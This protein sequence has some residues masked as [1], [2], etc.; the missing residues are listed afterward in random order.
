MKVERGFSDEE[1]ISS[2]QNNREISKV[3]DFMY[4]NYFE[5]LKTIILSNNG[6]E[7]DAQDIMQEVFVAFI[8]LVRKEKY[9][10]EASVRSFL[11]TLT[12]NMWFSEAR[13]RSSA[14]K[15]DT[16]FEDQKDDL[17]KDVTDYL[18]YSEGLKFVSNLF[19]SLGEVCKKILTLF[20]FKDLPMR[21]ILEHVDYEN[22]QVLRN[23]KYKCQRELIKRIEASPALY[24]NLKSALEHGR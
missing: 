17:E 9:R 8:D 12:R 14:L 7:E 22:E 15:R 21:E 10:K 2:I 4:R 6:N 13:K 19:E 24:Q 11:Y 5:M 16:Y 20:Y 23:K 3:L 1:I 18:E